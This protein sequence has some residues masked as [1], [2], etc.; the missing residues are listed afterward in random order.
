MDLSLRFAG[1][2]PTTAP[3]KSY[4]REVT[5]RHD[6]ESAGTGAQFGDQA[7]PRIPGAAQVR[8]YLKPGV[9]PA[10]PSVVLRCPLPDRQ[11]ETE[12]RANGFPT[13]HALTSP[14]ARAPLP[15]GN[16]RCQ[17]AAQKPPSPASW[18]DERCCYTPRT[19][20][21]PIAALRAAARW[22]FR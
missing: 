1:K 22:R 17:P 19:S 15:L 9:S 10:I 20:P 12:L 3:G 6:W 14:E 7:A 11:A 4:T 21:P 16:P 2:C 8:R 13:A 5:P 18:V